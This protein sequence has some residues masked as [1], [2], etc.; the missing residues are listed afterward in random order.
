[1]SGVRPIEAVGWVNQSNILLA[2]RL[3]ESVTRRESLAT[4]LRHFRS[5]TT[6]LINLN[7]VTQ[8][9]ESQSHEPNS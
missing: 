5:N 9:V 3:E 4:W 8:R 7:G 2:L 1:M 6:L